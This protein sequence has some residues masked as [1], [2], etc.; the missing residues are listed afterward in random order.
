MKMHDE[1]GEPLTESSTFKVIS[2]V[3]PGKLHEDL[4]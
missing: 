3:K 2:G 4:I 1:Y